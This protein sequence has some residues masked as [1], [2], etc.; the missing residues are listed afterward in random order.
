LSIDSLELISECIFCGDCIVGIACGLANFVF[1][2][3]F[4]DWYVGVWFLGPRFVVEYVGLVVVFFVVSLVLIL[5]VDLC[6][7]LQIGEGSIWFGLV[8]HL[9]NI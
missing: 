2:F 9:T 6:F 8:S 1:Q 7:S 4:A 3:D 5:V